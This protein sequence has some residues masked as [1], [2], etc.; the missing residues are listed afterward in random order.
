[1][2]RTDTLPHFLTDVADA[3]REKK[4]SQ[5]TI[6]ASDFDTEIENLPSG[7]DLNDYFTSTISAGTSN[8]PGY[9][10]MIKN[11]P[12]TTI[13]DGASLNYAFVGLKGTTIPLLDTSNVMYMQY[14]FQNC[15]NL[16][17]IPQINTSNVTDMRYMFSGCTALSQVPLLN[18]SSLRGSNAFN[19]MFLNCPSLTTQSLDNVL[20]MCINATSYSSTKTLAK[21]GFTST[22]YPAATIQA[23][24]HYQDFI[25]AGWTIGY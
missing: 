20:Q 16:I 4:G 23:L 9:D 25:D 11:I 18:T 21:L 12:S 7:A 3:I 15:E 22:N 14:M 13:V 24:P 1:M 5:E 2:A 8:R 17:T 10:D 19:N 6:Q